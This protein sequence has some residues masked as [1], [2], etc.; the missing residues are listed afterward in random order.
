MVFGE[1][2]GMIGVTGGPVDV[3]VALAD[4]VV[5]PAEAHVDGFGSFLFDGVVGDA[6]GSA[7]VCGDDSWGLWPAH[8]LQGSA[9]CCGFLAVAKQATA[10]GFGGAGDDILQCLADD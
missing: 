4:A 7:V 5:D 10:F 6:V 9:Q 1:A 2:I 3:E 8:F